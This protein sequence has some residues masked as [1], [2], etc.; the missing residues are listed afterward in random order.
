M[1]LGMYFLLVFPSPAKC[2]AALLFFLHCGNHLTTLQSSV[3]L[4]DAEGDAKAGSSPEEALGCDL[5]F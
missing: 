2:C 1:A 3:S 4:N 5:Y